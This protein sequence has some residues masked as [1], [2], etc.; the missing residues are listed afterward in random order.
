MLHCGR[1]QYGI[2]GIHFIR[3]TWKPAGSKMEKETQPPRERDVWDCAF[4]NDGQCKSWKIEVNR[5]FKVDEQNNKLFDLE[6][7]K[8]I[9]D[10][11]YIRE[12]KDAEHL[13]HGGVAYRSTVPLAFKQWLQ[14]PNDKPEKVI[15]RC[16]TNGLQ[17]LEGEKPNFTQW[18]H[19]SKAG[20]KTQ[21]L[22]KGVDAGSWESIT[23]LVEAYK[24]EARRS[25][26]ST[27]FNDDTA[28]VVGEYEVDDSKKRVVIVVSTENLIL[29]AYRQ[30]C[31]GQDL[32]FN[33][34]ASY[35]YTVAQH[36]GLLPIYVASP[37]QEGHVVAYSV[38]NKEDHAAHELVFEN[39]KADLERIVKERRKRGD[40]YV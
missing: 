32:A 25:D 11:Y 18:I 5:V 35:K 39:V 4:L 1:D 23:E 30:L 27:A 14:S 40:E 6:T 17:F 22:P 31:Y 13:D 3:H 7:G 15:E 26:K 21:A 37:T 8:A 34:D 29:N 28:Y 9:I 24:L 16:E 19:R 2:N 38:I 33:V 12:M 36:Y 10:Y 20:Y